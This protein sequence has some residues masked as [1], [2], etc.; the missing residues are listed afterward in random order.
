ME[1][2]IKENNK[3]INTYNAENEY[4]AFK[5]FCK[6]EGLDFGDAAYNCVANEWVVGKKIYKIK[7][8]VKDA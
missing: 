2:Q 5:K 3:L 6:E 4:F 1:F 8:V 7:E